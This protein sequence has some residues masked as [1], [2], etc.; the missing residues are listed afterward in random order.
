[1]VGLD[2]VYAVIP[3][4]RAEYISAVGHMVEP[5]V[6]V[7]EPVAPAGLVEVEPVAPAGLVE[8]ERVAPAGLVVVEPV[9][10]AGLV[11]VERAERV[12]P[13]ERARLQTSTLPL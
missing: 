8:V 4:P 12:E 6:S 9:A 3:V 10:P 2:L 1:M 13:A 11:E 5:A 7:V